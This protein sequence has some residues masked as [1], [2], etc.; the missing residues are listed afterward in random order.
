[1]VLKEWAAGIK[2]NPL[3]ADPEEEEDWYLHHLVEIITIIIDF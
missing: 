2:K 1:M 3:K